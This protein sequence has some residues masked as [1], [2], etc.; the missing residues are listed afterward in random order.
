MFY[1]GKVENTKQFNNYFYSK[2]DLYRIPLNTVCTI[3]TTKDVE[4]VFNKQF[5]VSQNTFSEADNVQTSIKQI[6]ADN[7]NC[8]NISVIIG[9]KFNFTEIINPVS[10]RLK[11]ANALCYNVENTKKQKF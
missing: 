8:S 11:Y 3:T 4:F 9:T 2:R 6:S 10:Y 7:L 1:I 5:Y